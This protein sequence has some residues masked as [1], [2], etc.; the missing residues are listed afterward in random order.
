[1]S[2]TPP[3][4]SHRKSLAG[5]VLAELLGM[6][7][8]LGEMRGEMRTKHQWTMARITALEQK[9]DTTPPPPAS[10]R[11]SWLGAALTAL[12]TAWRIAKLAPWRWIAGAIS[13]SG[14]AAWNWLLPMIHRLFPWLL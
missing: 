4:H 11:G 13:L 9:M 7:S 2:P 10:L 3:P 1:M 5:Q 12:G 14:G 6:S 8:N